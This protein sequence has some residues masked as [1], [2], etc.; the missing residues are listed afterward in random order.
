MTLSLISSGG[1]ISFMREL[2][3][4][5]KIYPFADQS[6][7]YRTYNRDG[8]ELSGS[9]FRSLISK[10]GSWWN[11]AS[12]KYINILYSLEQA[13]AGGLVIDMNK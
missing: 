1:T 2:D 5:D 11:S 4:K 3:V 13:K 10:G 7:I 8:P 6:L 12:T 9:S